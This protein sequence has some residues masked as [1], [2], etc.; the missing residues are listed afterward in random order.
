MSSSDSSFGSSFF[1]VS[2]AGAAP[3]A[4]GAAAAAAGAGPDP[5]P[6]ETEVMSLYL[7][8]DSLEGLGEKSWPV[9]LE[10]DVGG[11]EKGGDLLAGD[12]DLVILKDESS[13]NASQFLVRSHSSHVS[14]GVCLSSKENK[15]L[16]ER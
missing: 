3:P 4:A 10:L 14:C 8:I 2:A 15:R 13:V 11:L 12:G 16:R 7:D 6:D 5:A 9:W 1:L